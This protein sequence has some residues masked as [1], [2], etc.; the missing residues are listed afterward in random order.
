MP[1]TILLDDFFLALAPGLL[2]RSLSFLD[3]FPAG[4]ERQWGADSGM[5]V[6]C[7]LPFGL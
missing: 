2:T 7:C 3:D 5:L 1:R 4:R 6:P